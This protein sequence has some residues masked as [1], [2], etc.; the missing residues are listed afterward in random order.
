MVA[1]DGSCE[2]IPAES[3]SSTTDAAPNIASQAEAAALLGAAQ[4][5]EPKDH[6]KCD[7]LPLS[8]FLKSVE[9]I[10]ACSFDDGGPDPIASFNGTY[11]TYVVDWK[12]TVPCSP[13]NQEIVRG[14]A[15]SDLTFTPEFQTNYTVL[16]SSVPAIYTT[17]NIGPETGVPDRVRSYEAT[18]R[19][20][21]G[22]TRT[23]SWDDAKAVEVADNAARAYYDPSEHGLCGSKPVEEFL[24]S[25][26]VTSACVSDSSGG[27]YR[28]VPRND[29]VRRRRTWKGDRGSWA[30]DCLHVQLQ[31]D[32]FGQRK[33]DVRA[34]SVRIRQHCGAD[35]VL[36]LR[37]GLRF[38]LGFGLR[39]ERGREAGGGGFSGSVGIDVLVSLVGMAGSGADEGYGGGTAGFDVR[40]QKSWA[41]GRG[42]ASR[43]RGVSLRKDPCFFPALP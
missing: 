14:V 4:W 19:C 41:A 38:G 34:S 1:Q 10:S 25:V 2:Q 15:G 7:R 26:D 21:E 22:S 20:P 12:G 39:H 23:C 35:L 30:G 42:A 32:G 8:D 37:F 3:L 28:G 29:S 27:L 31:R 18:N 16:G 36:G 40:P 9:V 33:S 43:P 11:V 6:V 24:S 13:E 5:Y 17:K